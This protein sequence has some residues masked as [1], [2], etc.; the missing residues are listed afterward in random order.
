MT[1]VTLTHYE[2]VWFINLNLQEYLNND[3]KYQQIMIQVTSNKWHGQIMI[4]IA[5]GLWCNFWLTS[6]ILNSNKMPSSSVSLASPSHSLRLGLC[7][8][9]GQIRNRMRRPPGP[10]RSGPGDRTTATPPNQ[11]CQWPRAAAARQS[12][13]RRVIT[14]IIWLKEVEPWLKLSC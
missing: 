3:G 5:W 2:H 13:V 9:D 8:R 1:S 14:S 12:L 7:H 6:S 4:Q 11:G 10:R